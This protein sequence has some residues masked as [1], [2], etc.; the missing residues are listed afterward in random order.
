M[1]GTGEDGLVMRLT[2]SLAA[3][4]ALT[5]ERAA[6]PDASGKRGG[7]RVRQPV[8][9]ADHDSRVAGRHTTRGRVEPA[10]GEKTQV[11]AAT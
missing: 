7:G 9:G 8:I 2:M 6:H 1:T 11:I 5:G 4:R 3:Y 10:S